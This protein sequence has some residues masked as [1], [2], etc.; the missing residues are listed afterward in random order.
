MWRWCWPGRSRTTCASRPRTCG[1]SAHPSST[2][3]NWKLTRS[4][5][6]TSRLST[7]CGPWSITDT[8]SKR[9]RSIPYGASRRRAASASSTRRSQL[10]ATGAG[11]CAMKC[12]NATSTPACAAVPRAG[13]TPGSC[14]AAMPGSSRMHCRRKRSRCRSPAPTACCRARACAR[15]ASAACAAAS[16]M[17]AQC[18]T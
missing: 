2:C 10:S 6:R 11:C 18:A 17:S 3:S 12:R 13:S 9:I 15:Q 4:R 5:S 14:L 1:S 7:G 16:P 8:T